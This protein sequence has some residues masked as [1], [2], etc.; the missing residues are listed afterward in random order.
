MSFSLDTLTLAS[1]QN[2]AQFI[3]YMSQDFISKYTRVVSIH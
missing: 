2:P 3:P 1:F